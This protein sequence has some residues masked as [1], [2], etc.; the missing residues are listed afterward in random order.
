[1]EIK[2]KVIVITG[3]SEGIGAATARYLGSLGA[4]IVLA[5][6]TTEKLEQVMNEIP[7]AVSI[8][9]D[10]TKPND[11][12]N[13][14][15]KTVEHF[16]RIDVLINNAGRS[17]TGPIET[18]DIEGYKA[19]FELNVIGP[20][21]AME[22][23]IP[24]MRKQGGG[25]ILNISSGV[26]KQYIPTLGGYAST[27]YALNAISLTA[28]TELAPEHIV[29]CVMHPGLTSTEFGNHSVQ[30]NNTARFGGGADFANGHSAEHVAEAIAKQIDSEEAEYHLYKEQYTIKE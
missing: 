5:A 24:I 27:K 3:A 16:G 17:I 4:K 19:I 30:S 12:A 15:D 13:L 28:R 11:I 25:M 26:S 9:T 10:M 21:R 6:R 29:V 23:V 7:G 18:L 20:L 1:M 2:D 22:H 14:L 8:Q